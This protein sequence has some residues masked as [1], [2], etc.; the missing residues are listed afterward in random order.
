M[1]VV[2]RPAA[3]SRAPAPCGRYA[4]WRPNMSKSPVNRGP[5]CSRRQASAARREHA[6]V[7][8]VGVLERL[9]REEGDHEHRQVGAVLDHLGADARL[10]GG[11]GVRGLG[12]AV[13][14]EQGG[15]AVRPPHDQVEALGVVGDDVEVAVR[16]PA[17]QVGDAPG[18]PRQAG[19]A[20][21][22]L[23]HAS[24]TQSSNA[25][26]TAWSM[27]CFGPVNQFFADDVPPDR[28]DQQRAERHDRRVVDELPLEVVAERV[29]AGHERH[30]QVAARRSRSRRPRSGSS[31]CTSSRCS[32]CRPRTRRRAASAARSGSRTRGRGRSPRSR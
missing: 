12:V 30:H 3:R 15:V 28:Q 14:P 11:A 16:Q 22:R 17:G 19:E 31:T 32:S 13:D 2:A 23:R 20:V 4:A 8:E 1:V 10:R 21:Q 27:V 29:A 24:V 26:T 18:P 25:S 6:G 7:G 5:A 9:A